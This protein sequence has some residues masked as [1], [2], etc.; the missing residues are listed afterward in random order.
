MQGV[1]EEEIAE[2]AHQRLQNKLFVEKM[3]QD[4]EMIQ[5][6]NVAQFLEV[7]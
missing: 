1:G 2:K 7:V 6:S 3:N 5:K 4:I